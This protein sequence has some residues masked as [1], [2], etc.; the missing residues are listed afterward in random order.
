VTKPLVQVAFPVGGSC[1]PAFTKSIADLVRFECLN[2]SEEYDAVTL[3]VEYS[4][5]LYVQ[6]NRNL[7]VE[8]AR[9]RGAEWLLQVDTDESFEPHALRWLMES[10]V[11]CQAKIMYGLYTN[12]QLG[13]A[14][15]EGSFFVV[16]MIFREVAS[17]EYQNI[18][19][20]TD[21]RCFEVDAAGSG[22]LLTH[23]SIFEKLEYPWFWLD[24]IL[25]VGKIRPQVMNEDISFCRLAR[26]AGYKL[27]VNPLVEAR[28]YKTVALLPSTF[29]HFL[30]RAQQVQEEMR[31]IG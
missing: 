3:P 19:P 9:D 13:P 28:H 12:V 1:H 8:L 29:R 20:P 2:P 31:R 26:E 18:V 17:G 7:L 27:W 24:L 14:P 23:L 30:S 10:A 4:S 21:S 22:M 6:E 5:S 15:A 25:P 11:R 16:D